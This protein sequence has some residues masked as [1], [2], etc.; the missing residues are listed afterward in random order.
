MEMMSMFSMAG[1]AF[2]TLATGY[3]WLVKV[4]RERPDLR[5]GVA[6]LVEELFLAPDPF[7]TFRRFAHLPY[8]LFLDSAMEHAE[9]GR[10]SY[11]TADPFDRLRARGRRTV[12]ESCP[13]PFRRV[14]PFTM[15]AEQLERYRAE[16]LAGLPPFQ[17]GAAGLFGYDLCHHIE[18]LPRPRRD[19]VQTPDLAVVFFSPHHAAQAETIAKTLTERLKPRC[20]I[21][22][23]GE[24]IVGNDREV[25][26]QPALSLW[27]ADWPRPVELEPFHI[28]LEH[29]SEGHS[30][31]GW[32]DSVVGANLA[33]SALLVLGDPFTFPV[34]EFLNQVNDDHKGLRVMGGMASGV[35][36]PG[37]CRLIVN[38]QVH[39]SGAVGVVLQG[40]KLLRS[41]VSQGC[42]P[43]GR[44]MVVTAGHDNLITGLGGRPPLQVLQELWQELPP[45][46]QELFQRG[47]HVGVVLN[48]YQDTFQRGDFLV[49]P[50]VGADRET[51]ALAIGQSVRIG[52]TV[53]L[54]VRD[55]ASADRD[56]REA[57]RA[58]AEALGDAGAA[59]ALLFTCNGRGS[60][61]FDVPDHD[62]TA[63]EDALGAPA[64]GFFC[65]GEIGPVG[66]R[67]FLHGF[68]ATMAVF[69]AS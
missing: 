47:L 52:Q 58:Q 4:R 3:F 19:D 15:L 28:T 9:L 48:E 25:E 26:W 66:G 57:L 68:T 54:H 37:Q 50:I 51:G 31:L 18:K 49:R 56:M 53:R 67:N 22:C 64:A 13:F 65:A 61:M 14:N 60:H 55:A 42:R 5:V 24:S 41:V 32:P 8:A 45:K 7:D 43:I 1:S 69:P 33:E 40:S 21:G 17:G 2:S 62:A 27:L 38:G 12:L 35:R 34:N 30:L 59:G 6:P 11:V 20:L 36:G 23:V 46:D 63:I 29:T 44:H 39:D 10:Y 16:P